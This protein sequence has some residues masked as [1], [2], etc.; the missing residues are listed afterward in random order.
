MTAFAV[1]E[2]DELLNAVVETLDRYV[3][4]PGRD[5]CVSLALYVA[6]TWA[7]D[8]AHATPYILV[9]SPEKR[10]GKS[11]LLEVLELLVA[12]PWRLTG[13]SEAALFRK[14]AKDRPSLLLDEID[15]IFGSHSERTEPLR[16]LLNAG[17]RRGASVARCVGERKDVEDFSIFCPKVLAGIDAGHRIHG[18]IRDRA[19]M[20]HMKRKTGAE[21]VERFRHRDADAD[22]QPIR[23]GLENWA[24]GAARLLASADPDLPHQLDDRAAEAWEPLLAIAEMAGGD[25]STRAR[26]AAIALGGSDRDEVT[27]GTL[28][29]RAIRDAFGGS[30]RISSADLLSAINAD[31][32]LPFGG[33]RD[34]RGLDGRALARELRAYG[35]PG[36]QTVRLD[37]RRT[38]KGYRREWFP[39]A[40]ERWLP[41]SMERSQASQPSRDIGNTTQIPHNQADVT[42]VTAVTDRSGSSSVLAATDAEEAD[43]E[44]VAARF[45][46]AV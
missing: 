12:R 34:G 3:V 5:E 42:D 26:E 30:D 11:R 43:L 19:V 13:A 8:G 14:I 32:Q 20:L 23:K 46:E 4:L 7:I 24:V 17:N 1:T 45:P 31:E 21:L 29:L 25:W 15:A 16:A 35:I 28:L 9:V 40:W 37:D 22:A 27:L 36:P 6:H 2:L 10:S 39:E 44:R 33:W 38:A 18:T 41:P